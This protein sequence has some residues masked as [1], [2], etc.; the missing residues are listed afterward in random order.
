MKKECVSEIELVYRPA[1]GVKPV[2]Q[3]SYEAY[4]LFKGKHPTNTL[5]FI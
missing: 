5:Q 3:T 4:I 1:I 2:V